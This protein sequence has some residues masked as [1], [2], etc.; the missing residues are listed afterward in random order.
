MYPILQ[1]VQLSVYPP[2]PQVERG[3]GAQSAQLQHVKLSIN[4]GM[5]LGETD[6]EY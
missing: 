5:L 6:S 1:K 3:G 2:Y 4:Y